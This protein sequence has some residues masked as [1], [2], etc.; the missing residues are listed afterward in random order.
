[1]CQKQVETSDHLFLQCDFAIYLW[2]WLI[3]ILKMNINLSSILSIFDICNRGWIPQCK[4]V[5]TSAII[6]IINVIWFC[7]NNQRFKNLKIT[8][9]AVIAM[10]TAQVSLS[11]NLTKLAT[12]PAISDFLVLKAFKVETHHPRAPRIVEVIWPPPI[13]NWVKC[14]TDGAA[15]GNPG[16][17]ACAGIFRNNLGE[18]YMGCFA[19]NLGVCNALFAKFMAVI[20]AVEC[21]HQRNWLNLWIESDSKLVT[22]AVK[23]P[24][25]VP[26]QIKNKWLNCLTLLK[27]MNFL[28]SHIFREAFN[29]GPLHLYKLEKT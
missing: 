22:L 21:A 9:T 26:W 29:G 6:T 2:Q 15:L 13:H 1:M 20:L 3:S 17:G 19:Q 5:I 25:I 8:R 18:N 23:S 28:L 11:G 10:I 7:I 27:S 12:G 4:L 24:Q 14:N 16:L